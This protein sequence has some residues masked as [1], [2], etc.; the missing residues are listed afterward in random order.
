M[1]RLA[2]NYPDV[3]NELRRLRMNADDGLNPHLMAQSP[4]LCQLLGGG[5]PFLA[6]GDLR[7]RLSTAA[8]NGDRSMVALLHSF[9]PVG[10]AT[11]RL[12]HTGTKLHVE[13]RRARDLSDEGLLKMSE[14]IGS[15]ARWKVPFMGLALNIHEWAATVEAYVM[16]A[17]GFESYR[18]P[19][20]LLDGSQL[21]VEH[22]R[23]DQGDWERHLYGPIR[24]ELGGCE[25][26]F[27]MRRIGTMDM[28]THTIIR[29]NNPD[30]EVR[31]SLQY[32][33]YV[34]DFQMLSRHAPSR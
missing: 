18:H 16:V 3:Y 4:A 22:R 20:L 30:V 25:R 19:R 21:K 15:R 2:G 1:A 24:F 9:T 29:S 34:I 26:Q 28:R 12:T 14:L 17:N 27:T 33:S 13:Y 31:S 11:A 6:T 23:V 10:D 8:A 32:L 7:D 5:D